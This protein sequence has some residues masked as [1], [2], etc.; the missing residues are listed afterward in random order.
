LEL[1]TVERIAHRI[2]EEDPDPVVRFRLLR[3][4]LRLKPDSDTLV[5]AHKETLKSRWVRELANEQKED[6]SWGRFHS[7]VKCKGK[8]VTTEAAVERRLALGLEASDPIFQATT[9]YLT[10]LLVGKVAFPDPPER[11]NRWAT[12]TQLFA[13]ATLARICPTLPVLD[14]PWRLWVEIAERAF[15]SGEYDEEAEIRAHEA[16]TGA[17]VKDSYLVLNNRYQ[18]ALLG[19]RAD[20]LPRTVESALLDWVWHKSDGIGYLEVPLAN[21]PRKFTA[22]TL[23]RLFT[24][25][26]ILRYF[27]SWRK[28]AQNVIDWL[29]AQ[30]K[31]T[32]TYGILD[33]EQA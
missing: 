3:D 18:L 19:S 30:K 23:D 11:N 13:A 27:P 9:K 14:E 5:R 25:I 24:S 4:V 2:L 28:H 17:S 1:E 32:Q 16:L 7:A 10:H 12:G 29:W 33:S 8:I 21:P 6:G 20:R 31:A 15:F 26:E 22:G